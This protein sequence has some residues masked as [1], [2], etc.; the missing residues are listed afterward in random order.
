M[1]A[2]REGR[3]DLPALSPT[4][5]RLDYPYLAARID[6][7]NAVIA[8]PALAHS[9][10]LWNYWLAT[11]GLPNSGLSA[12]RLHPSLPGD[13]NTAIFDDAHLSAGAT[14]RNLTALQVLDALY[15]TVLR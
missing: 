3:G 10:P 15:S 12:D 5:N 4:H 7:Y 2:D 1:L 14:V 6:S 13:Q 8:Q 11:N 9:D